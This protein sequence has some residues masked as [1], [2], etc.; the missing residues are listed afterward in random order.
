MNRPAAFPCRIKLSTTVCLALFVLSISTAASHAQDTNDEKGKTAEKSDKVKP[1]PK[2]RSLDVRVSRVKGKD[3][4]PSTVVTLGNIE[5]PLDKLAEKA[6]PLFAEIEPD[7]AKR[8]KITVLIR[9]DRSTP[10]G[11]VQDVIK[12]AQS[13]GFEKFAL[14]AIKPTKA[15][16]AAKVE[17]LTNFDGKL[18]ALV[19]D[20]RNLG[21]GEA[22]IK[23]LAAL[24]VTRCDELG[25]PLTRLSLLVEEELQHAELVRVMDVASSARMS[26][27]KS[28]V[29]NQV[30]VAVVRNSPE[31]KAV[32]IGIQVL[33]SKKTITVSVSVG[34]DDG[35]QKGR[36]L[37]VFRKDPKTG[38]PRFLGRV[39]VT[40]VSPDRSIGILM[41]ADPKSRIKT[42][43]EVSTRVPQKAAEK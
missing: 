42:G 3:G 39:R 15:A 10:A 30:G 38:K 25:A 19:F 14:R 37:F 2:E 28:R 35:L 22:A 5:T 9:A 1:V 7:R 41:P 26:D 4:K 6:G 32:V 8:S 23:K 27:G 20:G 29:V 18:A 36:V 13:E 21:S 34:A 31:I 24:L 43:D 12:L 17:L 33:P 40:G 16:A 11:D